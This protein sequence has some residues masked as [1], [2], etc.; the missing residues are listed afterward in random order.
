MDQ[1]KIP[2]Q[3]PT[4]PRQVLTR[5]P[6]FKSISIGDGAL[7]LHARHRC[8]HQFVSVLIEWVRPSGLLLRPRPVANPHS[9]TS[10]APFLRARNP[11]PDLILLLPGGGFMSPDDVWRVADPYIVIDCKAKDL[12][13][14]LAAPFMTL[15]FKALPVI[16]YLKLSGFS[17]FDIDR[18]A[19]L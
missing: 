14:M 13:C 18:F 9:T 15:S 8:F 12:G 5:I 2:F 1:N 17:L 3:S 11:F 4:R 6:V 10:S 19:L 16:Q 7:V